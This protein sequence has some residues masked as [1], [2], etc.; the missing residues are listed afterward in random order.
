[1]AKILKT[2]QDPRKNLHRQTFDRL[3]PEPC[4]T[5]PEMSSKSVY[6]FWKYLTLFTGYNYTLSQT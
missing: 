4:P 2:T 6:N 1:M 3:L 5:F